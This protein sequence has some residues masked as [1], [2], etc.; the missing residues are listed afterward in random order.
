LIV[1]LIFNHNGLESGIGLYHPPLLRRF[2][3]IDLA[4]D[5]PHGID[6]ARLSYSEKKD[7]LIPPDVVYGIPPFHGLVWFAGQTAPQPVYA[8]PYWEIPELRGRYSPD[9]YHQ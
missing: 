6:G 4:S 3:V 2:I 5:D 7:Q 8:P 1:F 9:P